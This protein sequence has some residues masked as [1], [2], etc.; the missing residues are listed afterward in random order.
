MGFGVKASR[1]ASFLCEKCRNRK[2]NVDA[3][4]L[5]V[6]ELYM[7]K[8]EELRAPHKRNINWRGVYH[9]PLCQKIFFSKQITMLFCIKIIL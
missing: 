2:K 3:R 9:R 4:K 7:A 6:M 5:E 8:A 1:P